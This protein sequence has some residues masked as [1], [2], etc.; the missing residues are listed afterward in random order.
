MRAVIPTIITQ[1]ASGQ[2]RI[3]LG[4]VKPT[5]DFNYVTD[6]V[7]AFVAALNAPGAVGQVINIGSG[8][9][10]SVGETAQSIAEIMGV[11]LEIETDAQRLRPETSEVER[12]L[13]ANGRAR[14]LLKW[15]PEYG[16]R[17]GL[18]RGLEQTIAWF[19]SN[20]GY[21]RSGSYE[22]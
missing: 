11:S 14:E 17:E 22:L 19:R 21:Y 9:E 2:R 4:A 6:T 5:R 16:S 18:R 10:I 13:A 3:R 20:S 8:F 1:L 12:L 15:A 7:A